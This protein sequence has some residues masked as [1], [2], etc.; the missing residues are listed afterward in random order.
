M[1]TTTMVHVRVEEQLELQAMQTLATMGWTVSNAVR[2]LLTRIVAE[3]QLPFT[4]QV[5]NAD[6][7]A[8]MHEAEALGRS[9]SARADALIDALEKS[10]K[11][12]ARGAAKDGRPH[13]GLR[14]GLDASAA[15]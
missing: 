11:P 10:V 7:Q 1:A 4:L 3:Q 15:F 6:T 13:Q 8:A 5:P 2:V 9:R 14:R 12:Q